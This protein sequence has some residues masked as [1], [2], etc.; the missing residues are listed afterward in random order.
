VSV[1]L[2]H[3][4]SLLLSP[5]RKNSSIWKTFFA[6]V[7]ISETLWNFLSRYKMY[8]FCNV[9]YTKASYK[10]NTHIMDTKTTYVRRKDIGRGGPLL[11]P[12]I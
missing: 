2:P 7:T 5:G 1:S 10:T 11:I 12:N 9:S 4:C 8:A 3:A 6:K